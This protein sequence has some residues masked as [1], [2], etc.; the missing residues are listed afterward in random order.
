[1]EATDEQRHSLK[2]AKKKKQKQ[3]TRE[4]MAKTCVITNYQ[5]VLTES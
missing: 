3:D 4:D 5:L 1:M 2:G